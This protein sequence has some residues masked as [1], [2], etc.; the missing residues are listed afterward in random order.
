ML[1]N[2]YLLAKFRFDAAEN[3]P[4]KNLQNLPKIAN[5]ANCAAQR[6]TPGSGPRRG[7][8]A[9]PGSPSGS[10]SAPRDSLRA[11][12][13]RLYYRE[14][15]FFANFW[16]ARSRLHQNE[17]LQENMRL[18]A[19][20]KHYKMN[21]PLYRSSL[22]ILAK[23]RFTTSAIFVKFQLFFLQMLQIEICKSLLIF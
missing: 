1:S 17:T 8:R 3:E 2:A 23:I 11:P 15:C 7:S 18:T 10:T 22:N 13:A 6:R 9:C 16:R 19:F 14:S 20:F 12:K 4:P 5:F 21:T